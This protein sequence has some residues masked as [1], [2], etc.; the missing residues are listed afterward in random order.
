MNFSIA[1]LSRATGVPAGTI[2][3]WEERHAF[4]VPQRLPSGHRRYTQADVER[5]RAVVAARESG[6]SLPAAIERAGEPA[7][8]HSIHALLRLRRPELAPERV[9]KS[10]MLALSHAIEDECIPR[11][12]APVL[13]GSFQRARFYREAQ[14][15]WREFARGAAVAVAL[16]DFDTSLSRRPLEV[17][18]DRGHPLER[19]WA[20]VCYAPGAAACLSGW[21]VPGTARREFELIWT[22][23]PELVHEAA[24]AAADVAAVHSRKAAERI[25]AAVGPPPPPSSAETRGVAALAAR[26]VAYVTMPR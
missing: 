15:R 13:V 1:E 20:V 19:E 5:I 17:R 8:A 4:P 24:L 9:P 18:V 6:L 3:M 7:R 16:A 22:V 25:R 12:Q 11:A 14:A 26:M 10:R 23:D 2:R 21:E